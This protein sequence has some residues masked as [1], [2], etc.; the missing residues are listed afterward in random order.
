M[1][2]IEEKW[3]TTFYHESLQAFFES[4][5]LIDN[6]SSF[7]RLIRT[8]FPKIEI[9]CDFAES[10]HVGDLDDHHVCQQLNV[11]R[12]LHEKLSCRDD[13]ILVHDDLHRLVDDF[14]VKVAHQ[15]ASIS[16]VTIDGNPLFSLSSDWRYIFVSWISVSK[17]G[18]FLVLD[19]SFGLTQVML[20]HYKN[21]L[22][23]QVSKL[24]DVS[25]IS[26]SLSVVSG[27][28]MI[29]GTAYA[30]ILVLWDAVSGRVH[31][32]FEFACRIL[33]LEMDEEFGVWVVTQDEIVFAHINGEVVCRQKVEKV[34]TALAALQLK[35]GVRDRVAI[36]G[37]KTG[38]VALMSARL[39]RKVLDVLL[40]PS[41]HKAEIRE[42]VV[43]PKMR[44]F[45][46]SDAAGKTFV[47]YTVG[48][49]CEG[50]LRIELFARCCI[51]GA[52]KMKTFCAECNRA[53]CRSC[54]Y[55]AGE[56]RKKM[57][58]FCAFLNNL[59]PT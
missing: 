6:R 5:Q 8:E 40:L 42:I 58:G 22:P 34:V 10:R 17:N 11:Q 2:P 29:V 46:T 14:W 28:F 41:E 25:W 24:N 1:R 3:F 59:V 49:H 13:D 56:L 53:V 55:R 32:R 23:A 26:K 52:E 36:V 4:R 35:G 45:V 51:C 15:P 21:Q 38:E 18:L 54:C 47:W 31:R 27:V 12:Q 57:C 9:D 44:V 33:L 37:C 16:F 30:N 20:I 50:N 43:G 48:L 39:D 7:M 19:F